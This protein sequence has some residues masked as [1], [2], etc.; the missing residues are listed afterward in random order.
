MA[1][2]SVPAP[3]RWPQ[4]WQNENP[5]GVCFRHAGQAIRGDD[6]GSLAGGAEASEAPHILQKFIPGELTVPH[7]AQVGP[8]VA[9]EIARGFGASAS[10]RRAPQ[11]WQ[12]TAPSRFTVPQ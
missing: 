7:E 1:A 3:S 8:D 9:G 4:C 2:D 5:L 11:P 6:A 10:P 12:K